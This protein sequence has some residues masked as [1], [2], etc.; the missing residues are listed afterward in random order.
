MALY[1]FQTA[2]TLEGIA[3]N[4]F[5]NA[6]CCIFLPTL[7]DSLNVSIDEKNV[8]LDKIAPLMVLLIEFFPKK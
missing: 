3:K 6:V 4:S 8:D 7:F 1:P 2:L 5:E